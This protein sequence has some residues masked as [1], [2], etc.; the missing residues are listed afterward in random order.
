MADEIL[1]GSTRF[2]II[3]V[4]SAADFA[5]GHI[6]GAEN[7]PSENW[8]DE[9]YVQDIVTQNLN[10]NIDGTSKQLIF[11]CA[12]SQQRGPTAANAFLK[13]LAETTDVYNGLNNI[14]CVF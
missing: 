3:D 5:E 13:K 7:F 2:K 14:T 4:R 10:S 8:S 9:T 6:K 12:K 11:H 1:A